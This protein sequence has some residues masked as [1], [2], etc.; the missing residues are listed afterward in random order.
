MTTMTNDIQTT[1]GLR[2]ALACR[3][4]LL[5]LLLTA[6][7]G[8]AWGEATY[9]YI[10]GKDITGVPAAGATVTS[11]PG[12]TMTWGTTNSTV[13]HVAPTFSY[14][15]VST[16][17]SSAFTT[18]YVLGGTTWP[19][20][21]GV[22]DP[23]ATNGAPYYGCYLKF[24]ATATGTLTFGLYDGSTSSS[25]TLMTVDGSD[26]KT[27]TAHLEGGSVDSYT[28]SFTYSVTTVSGYTYY[29]YVPEGTE[30]GLYG[31]TFTCDR[32]WDF[33]DAT[34]YPDGTTYQGNSTSSV[35]LNGT[36]C[37]VGTGVLDGL[38]FQYLYHASD[39]KWE[40]NGGTLYQSR[41]GRTWGVLN[42]D[43]GD[44]VEVTYSNTAMT[45]YGSNAEEL[46]NSGTKVVYRMTDAGNLALGIGRY[47]RIAKV[48][49]VKFHFAES[50][51]KM[52]RGDVYQTSI[53]N[54]NLHSGI[55]YATADSRIATV[56]GSGRITAVAGGKTTVTATSSDGY[57]A[58]ILV[59]VTIE[60][61]WQN[62]ET[63][64]V[65]LLDA[66]N[67]NH[68]DAYLPEFI[69]VFGHTPT[70]TPSVVGGAAWF[71]SSGWEAPWGADLY[72]KPRLLKAGSV[73][74]TVSGTGSDLP[75]TFTLVVTEP[76]AATTAFHTDYYEYAGTGML[77][78]TTDVTAVPGITMEYGNKSDLTLVVNSGGMTVVKMIDGNGFSHPNLTKGVIPEGGTFYKFTTTKAGTLIISGVFS[79]PKLYRRSDKMEIVLRGA[80]NTRSAVLEEGCTYYLYNENSNQ[81]MLHSFRYVDLAKTLTF[82]NPEPFITIDAEAGTFTNTAYSSAGKPITYSLLQGASGVSV[83]P[84]NGTVTFSGI[85]EPTTVVVQATDGTESISYV[86]DLAKRTWIFND[87]DKWTTSSSDLSTGWVK[88]QSVS[89]NGNLNIGDQYCMVTTTYDGSTELKKDGTTPLPE[90]KGLHIGIDKSNER[91]YIAPKGYSSNYLAFRASTIYIPE[92]EAGQTVT[93]Q[94]KGYSSSSVL[95]MADSAG[96]NV[97]SKGGGTLV[98]NVTQT[99]RVRISANS[100]TC[101]I[102]SISV[103]SPIQAVGSLNYTR[104]VLSSNA[105]DSNHTSSLASSKYT[106]TDVLGATDLTG[107]YNAPENF[108]S[109]DAN[110]V[111]VDPVTGALTAVAAGTAVISATATAKNSITHQACVTLVAMVEVVANGSIRIRTINVADL[112]YKVPSG[113]ISA[114][115]GLDRRIPGF[116][117]TFTG[118]DGLKCNTPSQLIFR[119]EKGQMT[120]TPRTL[121]GNTVTITKA[122][123]TVN[124]IESGAEFT[125]NGEGHTAAVGVTA[126]DLPASQTSLVLKSTTSANFTVSAIKLYYSC[127]PSENADAC[128]DETKVAPAFT[129][130]DA[131]LVRVPGDGRELG[132]PIKLTEG[133]VWFKNF[134]LTNTYASS[135]PTVATI[136]SDGTGGQLIASGASTITATFNATTYF[137]SSSASY[138]VSNTLLPGESYSGITVGTGQRIHIEAS[139]SAA[140]TDLTVSNIDLDNNTATTETT[141][142]TYGFNRER[143]SSYSNTAQGNVTLTNNTADRNITIYSVLVVTPRV[144]AWLY[145]TGQEENYKE[146]VHFKGFDTGPVAGFRIMD[147]GDP[148]NPV[149]L[150]AAYG[151]SD[152]SYSAV[153]SDAEFTSYINTSTGNASSA[154]IG[155][156]ADY[157]YYTISHQLSKNGQAD[158]Y[159]QNY[160]AE[161]VVRI[162]PFGSSTPVVWNFD[163]GSIADAD[164]TLGRGWSYQDRGGDNFH[165]GYFADYSPVLKGPADT[166]GET[167]VYDKDG[168]HAYHT[169]GILLKDE[170]RWYITRGLRANLSQVKSSIKFPVK[171]GMEIDIYA[172]NSSADISH[173]ISNVTDIYGDPT[174]TLYIAVAGDAA[175]VHNY[176]LA[177]EDGVVEL[178]S[179]D[180]VGMYLKSITL[181]V[182]KIHFKDEIVTVLNTADPV[183]NAPTNLPDAVIAGNKVRYTII[184]AAQFDAEGNETALTADHYNDIATVGETSGVVTINSSGNEGWVKIHAENTNDKKTSLEP[185]EGDYTL[186]AIDFRFDPNKYDVEDATTHELKLDVYAGGGEVG[187]NKLP[188]GY[189]KVATAVNYSYELKNGARARLSQYTNANP[190]LTTYNLTVYGKGND[191]EN[192]IVLTA[193]TGRIEATCLLTVVDQ[194]KM[195]GDIAPVKSASEVEADNTY[196]A[197]LPAD[198]TATNTALA[199]SKAGSADYTNAEIAEGKVTLTGLSGY[200]AIRVIATDNRGTADD[201]TDDYSATFVLTLAYPASTKKK[202][203]FYRYKD[204][205]QS[206]KGQGHSDKIADYTGTHLNPQTI[207]DYTITGTKGWTTTTTWNKIY[208]NGDK[209]PRWAYSKSVKCDNAFIIEETAGL[210]IETAP[211]SFYVDNNATAGYI[212]IGIHSRATITIPKLKQGD[213]VSLNLSRVIPNNGAII[214][215]TNVTD[216]AGTP[217]TESFT[218]TRSQIDYQKNGQLATDGEGKRIIPGYYTFITQANGDVSFTLADE[219]YLD[220]LSIEIYEP[221]KRAE[222]DAGYNTGYDPE[223]GYDYTMLP[224]KLNTSGYPDAPELLLKENEQQRV[225]GLSFCHPMWS[226]S[227]GPAR[228]VARGKSST[229][230]TGQLDATI[231]NEQWYSAGGAGY[232]DGKITVNKGHGKVCVRME[233]Y[234]AE[235]K[236]LIGYTPDYTLTVGIIPHQDYPYTWNFT[237]ISGGESQLKSNS[238]YNGIVGDGVTWKAVGYDMFELNTNTTGGSF[239][240]PGGTFVSENRHL[241]AKGSREQL[242]AADEGCDELNGLGITGSVALRT[243]HQEGEEEKVP[244]SASD[245]H[246]LHYTAETAFPTANPAYVTRAKVKSNVK[247]K[248]D[249]DS[250]FS[251]TISSGTYQRYV[252]TNT[253][254]DK[255]SD[256]ALEYGKGY[257]RFGQPA[258]RQQLYKCPDCL[259]EPSTD[260]SYVTDRDS[261]YCT[262]GTTVFPCRNKKDNGDYC[263]S[264]AAPVLAVEDAGEAT[265]HTATWGYQMDG[266]ATK[267]MVIR[268]QRHFRNGDVITIMAFWRKVKTVGDITGKNYGVSLYGSTDAGSL[269]ATLYLSADLPENKLQ[270]LTYTIQPGD[271]L[272]GL[273]EIYI[274]RADRLYSAWVTDV[275][276]TTKS[277]AV[278]SHPRKLT[279]LSQVTITV[280]DLKASPQDWIYVK[281]SA[282]PTSVTNATAATA[283]DGQDAAEGV[284]KYKVSN[285]GNC[286]LT[287]A[288][289]TKIERIGVTHILKPITEVGSEGWATESRDRAIDHSLTGLFTKNDVN[290]YT[291]SVKSSSTTHATVQLDA[292]NS[293]PSD[294][295]VDDDV[296]RNANVGVPA[297]TGLVLRQNDKTNLTKANSGGVPLF[298]PAMTTSVLP[299]EATAFLGS[300]GNRMMASVDGITDMGET[301]TVEGT[302][303]TRFILAKRFMTWRQK[304]TQEGSGAETVTPTNPTVFE[305]REAP[306]FYRL[307][308]FSG[309]FGGETKAELNALDANK[310]YLLLQTSAL[311]KALWGNPGSLSRQYV[312]IL[313]I[314]DMYE[315]ERQAVADDR[316]YDLRGRVVD[317]DHLR[318]GVYVR[319]GRKIVVR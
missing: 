90:T 69:N 239:Y 18:N 257:C 225:Y 88:D 271:G 292:V 23:N 146:Q 104:T 79:T 170:F 112:L 296:E 24:T 175:P 27:V 137:A 118:G 186:Y 172:A 173:T 238:A 193:K 74:L 207:S 44:I 274:Y 22:L 57:V 142:M 295:A 45:L 54:P 313:G 93:V 129:F 46:S 156:I 94:W 157:G 13:G 107:A 314:S 197:C 297:E 280:P 40:I 178:K 26:N 43:R 128:L 36:S 208:R 83:N 223:N 179:T 235:G 113:G 133:D 121:S 266:G 202:W 141:T 51:V 304:T 4:L 111:V 228:Y 68:V 242:T 87:N 19:K 116:D 288:D 138:N 130:R 254:V 258:K 217:V 259:A 267:Y 62:T 144:R 306:V 262:N 136:G 110:V 89:S 105:G 86:L 251:L 147:V 164:N 318:P 34:T 224:V 32:V 256:V 85:Y 276:V 176:F 298:A 84:E 150:T 303:Y 165:Y 108:L 56:D 70:F 12:I 206:Q 236:Y 201:A 145:Y 8:G 272:A 65:S 143:R 152:A 102:Y 260:R 268:P 103:S 2:R 210:L 209:E 15:T 261:R 91:M 160:T 174:S 63:V 41:A 14:E 229:G 38:A 227:V 196:T 241:G 77:D 181:R 215:A 240:V 269:G 21:S 81:P 149:D 283:A 114:K 100:I 182:P 231:E 282:A 213:L 212:H 246:L 33:T 253:F 245:T 151:L 232:V 294:P 265:T 281:S 199:V 168:S 154:N 226:T 264:L 50:S 122:Q 9:T 37:N 35:N 307:Y 308:H 167:A 3:L 158:G 214:E 80:G 278:I 31:F 5:L 139:A 61:G 64:T 82:R 96:E 247:G 263:N 73:D 285:N 67:N 117:L 275:D 286:Q 249:Q 48:Q 290:A 203:E 72:G 310:A 148:E 1:D 97:T 49:A 244:T 277:T 177:A 25:V 248:T 302:E 159:E 39:N 184:G 171:K 305:T 98:L 119:K 250:I 319:G 115:D 71:A 59:D 293:D 76:G 200:G 309:T 315:Q 120:I 28:G 311:P 187:Y 131:H 17:P 243:I 95:D 20:T 166:Y 42:L 10:V 234:T 126:I 233:N 270:K 16:A 312:G 216:L 66:D 55:T 317:A 75:S 255:A 299:T 52:D 140:R 252:Y 162:L 161:A 6:G 135:A 169:H 190:R 221:G 109:S 205:L 29:L 30:I 60:F 192:Q 125:L 220:V 198:F 101:Y 180:K 189:N 204:G 124:S 222:A 78:K 47:G 53:V 155:N 92:V 58:T 219:G 237:N 132:N 287:F 106:I 153:K 289:G 300:R 163:S 284:W 291:V 185:E 99:G 194:G 211:N 191:D 279:A 273:S 188:K 218:I 195:F 301:E 123:L 183:S 127:S 7:A 230:I 134:A 316:V 11:V